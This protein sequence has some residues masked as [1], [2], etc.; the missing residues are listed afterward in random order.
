MKRR[1]FIRCG[2]TAAV[3]G[4]FLNLNEA[5]PHD[6]FAGAEKKAQDIV[7]LGRTGIKVSRLAQGTGTH[8]YNKSSN[9]IRKLGD[10][11][12]A[13]LLVAGVGNGLRFWDLA[14]G[15]GS[16]PHAGM[17]LKTVKRDQVVI[18]TKT[19][20]NTEE[21]MRSDLDRFRREIG[22]DHIDI[23][24]LH[25]MLSA[26]WPEK[27]AGAMAV[28]SEAKE[29]G[30]I[31]AHGVSCHN[32]GAMKTAAASD[33]VEVELQRINPGGFLMD[34]DRDTIVSVLRDMKRKGQ[35]IIGM[36]ILGEGRLR[37]RVD[38]ALQFAL[39]Q[40]MLDCFTIGAENQSEMED[41]LRRIPAAS[42][43]A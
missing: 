3:G 30:I 25:C 37:D 32:L 7:T 12:L 2:A 6:R 15:Y 33:W 9:Q 5:F 18:M 22:S 8:G 16:H 27:K 34:G 29:K 21:Q 20:A 1:D 42:V 11:G 24:L 39:A 43:R 36:K 4:A 40:D 31:K 14:D 23:V 41:L 35:G 38:E 19:S 28:L 10:R 26:D 13:D 17:A